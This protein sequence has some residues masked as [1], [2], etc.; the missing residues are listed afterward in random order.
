[1]LNLKSNSI[2]P[3]N[4]G[5]TRAVYYN[6]AILILA[7]GISILLF[8]YL[9]ATYNLPSAAIGLIL[10]WMGSIFLFY[11]VI[12]EE[13]TL[14]ELFLRGNYFFGGLIIMVSGVLFTFM[15]GFFI[16]KPNY[17][18]LSAIEFGVLLLV[19]G[20]VLIVL[21]ARR[22]RDYTK[23]NGLMASFAGV[24]LL[25][26]GVM[27]ISPNIIYLSVLMIVMGAIWLGLRSRKAL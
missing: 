15:G 21:S 9:L 6:V 13:H 18:A 27:V 23:N 3:L 11:T 14:K 12:T 19:F 22:S 16:N 8:G 4:R 25:L 2:R 5:V 1:M 7:L 10:V 24:I 26:G 17:N 20:A